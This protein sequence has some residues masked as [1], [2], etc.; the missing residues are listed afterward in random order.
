MSAVEPD[1]YPELKKAL[2]DFYNQTKKLFVDITPPHCGLLPEAIIG[3]PEYGQNYTSFDFYPFVEHH[4][5]ANTFRWR[6]EYETLMEV[7]IQVVKSTPFIYQSVI[8]VN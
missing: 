5:S 1:E 2:V 6:F 4:S 3:E 7:V 8:C